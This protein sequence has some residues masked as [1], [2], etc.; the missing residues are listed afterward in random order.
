MS[1]FSVTI[2]LKI[3]SDPI[4]A[5]SRTLLRPWSNPTS[6]S[7]FRRRCGVV[8]LVRSIKMPALS[9]DP[10]E[11]IF[12]P[13]RPIQEKGPSLGGRHGRDLRPRRCFRTGAG[14]LRC[15]FFGFKCRSWCRHCD[16]EP[17]IESTTSSHK[18]TILKTTILSGIKPCRTHHS[19]PVLDLCFPERL[20]HTTRGLEIF[21]NTS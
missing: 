7:N 5:D 2:L 20:P 18:T 14:S 12:G 16:L 15:G 13:Q 4:R 6:P 10:A 19:P 8:W 1:P 11:S 3:P 17:A 21:R 9:G